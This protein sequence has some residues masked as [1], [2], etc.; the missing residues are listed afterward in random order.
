M[1]RCDSILVMLL[2]DGEDFELCL[3]G[4][5]REQPKSSYNEFMEFQFS[6]KVKIK[7]LGI[8]ISKTATLTYLLNKEHTT[9]GQCESREAFNLFT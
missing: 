7:Q 8:S 3:E 9:A 4:D 1:K 6:S 2:I 5:H